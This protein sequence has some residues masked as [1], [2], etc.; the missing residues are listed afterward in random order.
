[1]NTVEIVDCCFAIIKI[2]LT[3][4]FSVQQV[5]ES[6]KR[7]WKC[8]NR[9]NQVGFVPFNILEPV[10]HIESPITRQ[11][12]V[13]RKNTTHWSTQVCCRLWDPP[14]IS[15]YPPFIQALGPP[16]APKPHLAVPPSPP[17][18]P[19]APS[20]T[21]S[22]SP[23]R[24]RSLPPYSQVVPAAEETEKGSKLYFSCSRGVLT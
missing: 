20:L 3:A 16:P 8:R 19:H 24:P 14:L 17:V 13:R 11:P 4:A 22:H 1:M 23:Q 12:S 21:P 5:I 10:A 6:S 15:I 18:L 2:L 9:F 7:W